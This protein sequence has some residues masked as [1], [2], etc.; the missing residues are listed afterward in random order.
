MSP[1]DHLVQGV[2]AADV[3]THAQERTFGVEEPRRV[4]P[5]SSLERRLLR[6]Q[7]VR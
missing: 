3:L 6:S 1:T 5:S 2:V 4:K 7:S